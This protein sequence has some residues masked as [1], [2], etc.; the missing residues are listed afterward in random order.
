MR[1]RHRFCP[2]ATED[3]ETRVVLSELASITP[4][5]VA[6][7]TTSTHHN[8]AQAVVNQVNLAFESFSSDY[9]QAEGTYLANTNDNS[10]AAFKNYVPQRVA[11]LASQLTLIFAHVPGSLKLSQTATSGGPVVLQVF[12]RTRIDGDART[13]LLNALVG[14]GG[15]RGAIPPLG[16]TG[17]T[18]TLYTDLA[19]SA[20]ETAQNA[21]QNSVVFLYARSFQNHH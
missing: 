2:A 20:I 13:S 21:T 10:L 16:T 6:R 8:P 15:N 12:L 3:L 19:I 5:K 11:L 1:K 17:T 9:L 4:V 18:A 7:L 14:P